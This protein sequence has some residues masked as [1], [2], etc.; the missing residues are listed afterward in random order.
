[1]RLD[2]RLTLRDCIEDLRDTMGYII[3]HDILHE[4]RREGDTDDRRDEIPPRMAS[5]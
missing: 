1:M 4:D 2:D 3:P 5:G